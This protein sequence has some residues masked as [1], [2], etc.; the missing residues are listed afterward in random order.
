MD[1]I[2]IQKISSQL[3][4][5][6]SAAAG[7]ALS[8]DVVGKTG[9]MTRAQ[10]LEW[11]RAI[12]PTMKDMDGEDAEEEIFKSLQ[13]WWIEEYDIQK[14]HA[15]IPP[16]MGEVFDPVKH[17]WTKPENVGKTVVEVQG[18]KRYRGT[19]AGAHEH[20]IAGHGSGKARLL[21]RGRRYKAPADKG[22]VRFHD[23][24]PGD[25]PKSKSE[26][27]EGKQ[28]KKHDIIRRALKP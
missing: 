15:P 4:A 28:K 26:I 24:K 27:A 25:P 12:Q 18:K 20:S 6:L 1:S 8:G 10:Q 11:E 21:E 13:D 5:L 17:R 14:E 2:P 9:Q 16:I 22:R 7:W 19:G 23:H 3:A